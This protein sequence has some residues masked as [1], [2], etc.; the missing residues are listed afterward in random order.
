MDAIRRRVL[1]WFA[2]QK[3]G[4]TDDE[5]QAGMPVK[6]QV[7]TPRRWELTHGGCLKDSGNRRMTRLGR[8]AIVWIATGVP[9]DSIDWATLCK[10]IRGETARLKA[11][12]ERLNALVLSLSDRIHKQSELLAKRAEAN[13]EKEKAAQTENS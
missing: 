8:P 7:Q 4:A 12:V 10:A 5:C 2:A 9:Y 11:E 3:N 13:G 6:H 1:T